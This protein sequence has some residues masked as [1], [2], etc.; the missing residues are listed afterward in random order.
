[1]KEQEPEQKTGGRVRHNLNDLPP[2]PTG[3]QA[4]SNEVFAQETYELFTLAMSDVDY[5]QNLLG[6]RWLGRGQ[7][8]LIIGQ[9]GIGKS[10]LVMQMIAAW[11][12]GKAAL[13][14]EPS[15]SL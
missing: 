4:P 7:T 15:K 3:R 14:I 9:S 1:M 13:G 12:C 8:G 10:V 2:L 11:S 6:N 5:S